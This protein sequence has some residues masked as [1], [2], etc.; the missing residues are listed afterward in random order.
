MI[1]PVPV[2]AAATGAGTA[3]VNGAT[4]TNKGVELSLN[5]RPYS[6]SN[7]DVTLGANYGR[8]IGRVESLFQGVQFIAY[9]TEGFGGS[10]GSSTVG[11]APGVI[12]GQDFVRCG[13]GQKVTLP[14]VGTLANVDSACGASAKKGSLYIAGTNNRPVANP[15]EGVIADPNPHWTS[16][17]T[18]QIRVGRLQFSTLFDIR[19]GGQVWDGTRSALDRFGTAAETEVRSSTAGIFGQNILND[20]SVAGPGAGKIAFQTL[21]DW[22]NWYTTTGGSASAVQSQFVED[23]SFVKW[24]ELSMLYTIDQPWLQSR[25]GV[26]Q[27]RDPRRRPQSPHVD[28]VQGPRSR[29][30]H[31]RRRVPHAG[32]RLLP[33]PADALVRRRGHAEPMIGSH[34]HMHSIRRVAL[35]GALALAGA[36]STDNF[37][38]GGE[39]STDP[40][41][42][43]QATSAQLLVGIQAN[44]WAELQ[45][46]PVRITGMWAQQFI[47]T[48]QQYVDTYNYGVSEAGITNGF[49]AA[50]YTGGGLVDIRRLQAQTAAAHDTVFHGIALVMEGLLMGTGADL[51]GDLTYTHALTNEQN[52]PLDPQLAV[53]DTVQAVLS[54]AIIDLKSTGPTQHR[55]SVGRSGVRRRSG[56]MDQA[57]A[58]AEGAVSHAHRRSPADG[59]PAGRRGGHPW[60][61]RRVRQLQRD[62]LRRLER[63]KL[64][65][66]VRRRAAPRL[67]VAE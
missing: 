56:E 62:L 17:L 61:H 39:L 64:L 43:I 49:H 55:S 28:Q 31:R 12:R 33:E 2:N 24:R 8:N 54:R 23:G 6:S 63:A 15:D 67:P 40:N 10:G 25:F 1:L 60:H 52:P 51:F 18:G 36:C 20:Q 7:V 13:F 22:Q 4:I 66:S 21:A 26:E 48:N 46:D 14:G 32:I 19:R 45:S 5:V 53:Y 42:P 47:G 30:E 29:D 65:V 58:H 50:L 34:R 44:L 3:L 38:S 11:Y 59:V 27:R 16:G 57:R 37:L 41:R 35:L 9:P